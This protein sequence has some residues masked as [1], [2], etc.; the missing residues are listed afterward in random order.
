MSLRKS[1]FN[2]ESYGCESCIGVWVKAFWWT[3]KCK[4]YTFVLRMTFH[5]YLCIIFQVTSLGDLFYQSYK[6]ESHFVKEKT[7]SFGPGC[8]DL[9][10]S[11][12]NI[13]LCSSWLAKSEKLLNTCQSDISPVP[14]I[15]S[16]SEHLKGEQRFSSCF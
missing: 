3:S 16:V 6:K 11:K 1:V 2:F 14:I 12:G 15:A 8:K 10:L 9:K 5:A 7:Y 4:T 13:E